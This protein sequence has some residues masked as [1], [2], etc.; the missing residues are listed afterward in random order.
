MGKLTG[1][2]VSSTRKH[3]R[4]TTH[5]PITEVLQKFGWTVVDTSAV[6]ALVPGFPD[7]V[8]GIGGTATDMVQAKT[9]DKADFTPAEIKF[10]KNWRGKPIIVLKSVEEAIVWATR[11]R[12]E[13]RRAHEPKALP[14]CV[15]RG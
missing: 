9:G 14:P 1:L 10:E 13:L 8:I 6:G 15:H 4:D 2:H 12:H 5:K 7:M 3:H 11:T